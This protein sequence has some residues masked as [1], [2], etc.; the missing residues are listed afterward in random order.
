[1]VTPRLDAV[2]EVTLTT[3][4]AGADSSAQGATQ[5]RFVTK[6]GT[7][8]YQ[9]TAYEYFQHETLNTNTFFNRLNGL[10]RP[11]ATVDTFGAS[12]GGPIVIPGVVDGRGKAFFFFNEEIS[13]TPNQVS[14]TR[15]VLR[16][17]SLRGVFTLQREQPDHGGHPRAGG[18]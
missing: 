17:S 8:S 10:P 13:W 6:S 2:E 18:T 16:D 12:F 11:R 5:V 14:R 9:G 1:M 7:N 4:T 3:A 15:R